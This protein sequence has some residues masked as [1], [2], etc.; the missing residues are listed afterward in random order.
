M[1]TPLGSGAGPATTSSYQEG[2]RVAPDELRTMFL[3]EALTPDQL[4][5]I[6]ERSRVELY[7]AGGTIYAEGEP[8]VCF[9]VLL[10][11][12]IVMTRRVAG[13]EIEVVRS[14][15]RGSYGGATSSFT[16]APAGQQHR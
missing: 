5:W 9:Y 2:Q 15:Q 16:P 4:A 1:T 13:D 14:S 6:A 11:G 12:T 3:F 10:A 8:A 7:P